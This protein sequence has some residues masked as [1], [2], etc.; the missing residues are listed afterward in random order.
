MKRQ[1]LSFPP[2]HGPGSSKAEWRAFAF[3]LCDLIANVNALNDA[4]DN[5]IS[6][7]KGEL[8]LMR[9][10][11]AERKPKGARE[12]VPAETVRR[13]EAA[14]QRGESTRF[15]AQ[16]YGVSAMTASRIKRRM[17]AREQ[18]SVT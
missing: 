14:L 11:I 7:L 6:Y 2:S 15:I 18:V 5:E 3:E 1:A 9:Q 4:R 17:K 10:R 13:I 12:A 16:Q 8:E